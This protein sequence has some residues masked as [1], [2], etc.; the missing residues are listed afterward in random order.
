[1]MDSMRPPSVIGWPG[2]FEQRTARI[3]VVVGSGV[4]GQTY[5]Y[6]RGDQL[7]E[8]PVSYW[9]DGHKWI[10]SP[11]YKNGTADFS[12]AVIPRCLE[13][14]STF[15][16]QRS[17]DPVSNLYDR[18]SLVVGVLCETCHGPSK[19]HVD[20]ETKAPF[21]A[22]GHVATSILNP[23]RFP[24]DREMDVCALC[25]NGLRSQQIAPAFSFVPGEPL[26]KY[27]Q[28]D[29]SDLP[30][31]PNVHGNQVGLLEKSRCYQNSPN[32]NCST[33]HDVHAPEKPA[34][35]YSVRCLSCHS[36]SSC[37]MFT[38]MGSKIADNCIDCHM[39]VEQTS[40]VVSDTAGDLLR[41]RMRNHWIKIYSG[42]PPSK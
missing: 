27:L 12:R 35:A 3:D 8:L 19:A 11:G 6:W 36:T 21:G 34:A 10:N 9:S 30:D 32:F 15:I 1:M 38:K 17:P 42:A 28:P 40:A 5:L 33:C 25:H 41:P 22:A 13:C 14:H 7:F 31:K 29:P 24:R 16:R 39:P 4:R 26:S 2:Q 20:L 23:A 18:K 37:G